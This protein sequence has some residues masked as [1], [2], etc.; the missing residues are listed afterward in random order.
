M[1]SLIVSRF[2][3]D[4]A[5]SSAEVKRAAEIIKANPDRR[6]IFVSAP[7]ST[8]TSSGITDMLYMCHASAKNHENYDGTLTKIL[9][10]YEEIVKGLGID[11]DI[12]AE[13]GSLRESLEAGRDLDFIGSRGEFIMG[14]I[15]A[16]FLG[17]DFVDASEL[18]FFNKDGTVDKDKTF[19][20]A[21]DKLKNYEHAVIPSFYGSLA[22]GRIKTFVRGDCDTAGALIA[23]AVKADLFEKWSERTK[24]Y[25]ADPSVIPNPEIIKNVT[26]NEAVELNY[27]GINIVRDSVSIMLNEAGI[28]MKIASIHDPEDDEMLISP[29]LPENISRRLVLCIAGQ[30]NFNVLRI[31]KYGINRVYG[32]EEKMFGLLSKHNIAC[33]HYIAGIHRMALIL[34][35]LRFDLRRN[36]ILADIKTLIQ[37]DS[38]T[39]E[40]GLSLIAIIGEGMGTVKGVFGKIF[41]ALALVGIKVQM[42]EEGSDDL[43]I[44]LGVHDNDYENAIKALYQAVILGQ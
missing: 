33:Q 23:C 38:I 4:A 30:K 25:S 8:H 16:K 13:I 36:E 42:I 7:G 34:K 27:I 6:Y 3:G 5:S 20:I 15:F 32:V 26:Y 19:T 41:T 35:N 12:Y 18:I 37:P 2:G 40:R 43:N 11:F 29:K 14:K 44:I 1:N 22:D 21:G 28:P 9:E 24:I 17:W 31:Q 10:R 39:V